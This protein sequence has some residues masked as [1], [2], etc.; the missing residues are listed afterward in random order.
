M[1]ALT[2]KGVTV[3]EC[4]REAFKKRVAPQTENFIKARPESKAVIDII[5]STQA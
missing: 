4:D 1:A 5:R 2:E 3:A